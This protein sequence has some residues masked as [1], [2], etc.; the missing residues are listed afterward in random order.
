MTD[1]HR[2]QLIAV[3]GGS[4]AGKGWFVERLCQVL[5]N[6]A[7]HLELDDFYRDLSHLPLRERAAQNF[8]VPEAIDWDWAL[9]VLRACRAGESATIPGYNFATHCRTAGRINWA[10]RPVILVDGLWLLHRPEIRTLFA[11]KI[12]LDTPAP[13][14]RERRLA[15]D[16]AER[17]YDREAIEHQL[18]T[19]VVPMHDRYVEPQKS[20]AD[21][22]LHQPFEESQLVELCDRLWTLLTNAAV[23]ARWEHETF[24]AELLSHLANHEYCN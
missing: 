18:R 20:W 22:V 19:A 13:L 9:Q 6:H 2:V 16:V 15:R 11:L 12:F 8:D 23:I 14:R 1:Y 3:V 21:L 7:C 17:G 4:G 10:P 24:R 5:G